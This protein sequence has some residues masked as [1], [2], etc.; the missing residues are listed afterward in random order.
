MWSWQRVLLTFVLWSRLYVAM[1]MVRLLLNVLLFL[2]LL[3]YWMDLIQS[4]LGL[5][6]LAAFLLS[7]SGLAQSAW[8][9]SELFDRNKFFS[10]NLLCLDLA[11]FNAQTLGFLIWLE[12]ILLKSLSGVCIL[13]IA[14]TR[15]ASAMMDA[16]WCCQS[17]MLNGILLRCKLDTSPILWT[18]ALKSTSVQCLTYLFC[19][20]SVLRRQFL[21]SLRNCES[22]QRNLV[23][24]GTRWYHKT[25]LKLDI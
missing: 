17:W 23:W 24:F 6:I 14:G 12:N 8:H 15:Y 20:W 25:I 19:S 5:F 16:F 22:R 21:G 9:F 2:L 4:T 7:T 18:Q 11:S 1:S 10:L 3:D 13:I